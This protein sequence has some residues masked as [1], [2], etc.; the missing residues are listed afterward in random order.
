MLQ[1]PATVLHV[2]ERTTDMQYVALNNADMHN[3]NVCPSHLL[4][5]RMVVSPE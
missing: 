4:K 1:L 2:V 3:G 5:L